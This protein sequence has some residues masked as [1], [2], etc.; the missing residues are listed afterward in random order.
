[1]IPD[2]DKNP[3]GLYRKYNISRTDGKELDPK[4]EFFILRLDEHG[5]NHNHINACRK[6]ILA[7]ADE[8]AVRNPKMAKD[9]YERYNQTVGSIVMPINPE[10]HF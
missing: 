5:F 6:A 1:M 8:I 9:L 2:K 4:A 10:P 3:G 7:Y